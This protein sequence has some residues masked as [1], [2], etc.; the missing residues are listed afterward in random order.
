MS[1]AQYA[2]EGHIHV[3]ALVNTVTQASYRE[4][5]R[6]THTV[7][8]CSERFGVQEGTRSSSDVSELESMLKEAIVSNVR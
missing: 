7:C 4:F 2:R 5:P 1:S 6:G 8:H 3:T